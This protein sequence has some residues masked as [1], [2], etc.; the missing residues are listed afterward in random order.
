MVVFNEFLVEGIFL[1]AH[2]TVHAFEDGLTEAVIVGNVGELFVIQLGHELARF[3][4]VVRL[5]RKVVSKISL[6]I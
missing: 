5:S 6:R 4:R 2:E 3:V 1:H